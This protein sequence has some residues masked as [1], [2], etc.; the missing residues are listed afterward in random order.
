MAAHGGRL[1]LGRL[2][3]PALRSARVTAPTPQADPRPLGA[4][5]LDALTSG[6]AHRAHLV[7]G[8]AGMGKTHL[9]RRLG[10][11]LVEAGVEP[12]AV[13]GSAAAGDVPLGAFAARLGAVATSP[14][15]SPAMGLVRHLAQRRA[16]TVLLVDN[17]DRLDPVSLYVVTHLVHDAR[18]R[19][20][21][22]VREVTALPAGVH[23]L[24]DG[25]VLVPVAVPPLSDGEA[26]ALA[27]AT[28]GGP[29][30]PRAAAS[31][32]AE[33]GGNPLHLRELVRGS[34]G[35]GALAPTAHGWDLVAPL[36]ASERL[37]QL[38]GERFD[39]LEPAELGVAA[40]LAAA[41][42]LPE[43]LLDAD[44]VAGLVGQGLVDRVPSGSLALRHPLYDEALRER[45]PAPAWRRRQEEAAELLSGPGAASAEA[46]GDQALAAD[47][48]RRATILRL[49]AGSDIPADEAL[50]SA[51]HA[52]SVREHRL[53]L[54]L[55][56]HVLAA[57]PDHPRARRLAGQAASDLGDLERADAHLEA[58]AALATDDAER[59]AAA[60]A[61][62]WH[63]ATRRHD[64]VAAAALVE[65]VL[66]D[67]EDPAE[68]A[69]V[70]HDLVQW[71]V[72]GG[73]SSV[74]PGPP[75][76]S[77]EVSYAH[78]LLITMMVT[79]LS[80]PLGEAERL[81]QL[82]AGVL[83][84]HEE[85]LPAATSLV[86]VGEVMALAYSGDIV[87]AREVGERA[88]ER[89]ARDLPDMLGAWEYTLGIIELLSD[90]AARAAALADDA[91]AHLAWR[92][93]VGVY[94]AAVAL[95]V[96]ASTALGR[97]A[98]ADAHAAALPEPALADP[99]VHMLQTWATAWSV[100]QQGSRT[101][102][103]KVL[104]EGADHLL[105]L[106][107]VFFAGMVA[108]GAARLGHGELVLPLL[109]RAAVQAGGG[110]VELFREH[111][112]AVAG[113]DRA[114]LAAVAERFAS[115][116]MRATATDA[117]TLLA[118]WA[119]KAGDQADARRWQWYVQERCGESPS[120]ALWLSTPDRATTLTRREREVAVRAASRLTN[121]EIAA[122]LGTSPS[123]VANQLASAYRK[124][125]VGNRAELAEALER[126]EG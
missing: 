113:R 52:G 39:Q 5:L 81:L 66:D 15:E 112:A 115:L 43:P 45:L 123:T 21:L 53:A 72:V 22:T 33:C 50:A 8:A 23:E 60:R 108:H 51:A 69:R 59:S 122:E 93:P 25:G 40:L 9:L 78:A 36:R 55:A 57:A 79:L 71:Q 82:L 86:G 37:A 12:V 28:V 106:D 54:R 92:D 26:A 83:P 44:G 10:V 80:G 85:E 109:E 104:S 1:G 89:D 75:E 3:V 17:V 61:R 58:A 11:A 77:D 29:L 110:V 95:G 41:G 114:A 73:L 4:T 46:E 111:A 103:A 119:R 98:A 24:Y 64:A 105:A 102:A 126:P 97:Q 68:V 120:M 20:V 49:R 14:D 62:G 76:A 13:N 107:Q 2:D 27:T 84:G 35:A 67:L 94:P 7:T 63:L 47:L 124:L 118:R 38:V 16:G 34:V 121:R 88:H 65:A 6:G 19:A 31:L 48:R 99:K 87:A 100:G 125:G 117:A 74:L 32:V 116:G 30:T 90:D 56:E 91:V 101:E 96:A 18:M 70:R 42:E